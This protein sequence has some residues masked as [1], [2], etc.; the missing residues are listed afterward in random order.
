ML[1]FHLSQLANLC[2]KSNA[3]E[4][5]GSRRI[6]PAINSDKTGLLLGLDTASLSQATIHAVYVSEAARE[7]I[8]A[9]A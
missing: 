6:W 7:A 2:C 1:N 4:C 3:S 9:T 5:Y 8:E